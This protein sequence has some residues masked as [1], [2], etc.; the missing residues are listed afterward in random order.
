MLYSKGSLL[1]E[2]KWFK[3]TEGVGEGGGDSDKLNM[4]DDILIPSQIIPSPSSPLPPPSLKLHSPTRLLSTPDLIYGHI[5]RRINMNT[6]STHIIIQVNSWLYTLGGTTISR[7]YKNIIHNF[8]LHK[9]CHVLLS[10]YLTLETIVRTLLYQH[11]F[12]PLWP[13]VSCTNIILSELSFF[14]LLW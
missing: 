14:K 7:T 4:G 2:D 10:I 12:W 13:L 6:K 5:L 11:Q 3:N 8:D 1:R 9:H